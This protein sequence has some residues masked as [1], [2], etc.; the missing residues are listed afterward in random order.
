VSKTY[1]NVEIDQA[2]E[3]RIHAEEQSWTGRKLIV[4]GAVVIPICLGILYSL[5][6]L[7]TWLGTHQP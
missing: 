1:V 2:G 3:D 6:N 7:T 4:L 5:A